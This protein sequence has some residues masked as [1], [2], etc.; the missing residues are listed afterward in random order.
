MAA[1]LQV[2]DAS[3]NLIFD[4]PDRVGR[5]VGSLTT[6][7]G[8]GGSQNFTVPTG[9]TPFWFSNTDSQINGTPAVSVSVSGTTCTVSWSGGGASTIFYGYY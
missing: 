2:W 9:C 6:T 8:G 7:A 1:G 3:G 5:I 4:T